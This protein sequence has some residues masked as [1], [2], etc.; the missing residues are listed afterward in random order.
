M[1]LFPSHSGLRTSLQPAPAQDTANDWSPTKT[2]SL[3]LGT[4]NMQ[5]AWTHTLATNSCSVRFK[6][7][8]L[9][10]NRVLVYEGRKES[11]QAFLAVF[12]WEGSSFKQWVAFWFLF[13]LHWKKH[14]KW[15]YKVGLISTWW[16]N[17]SFLYDRNDHFERALY[18]HLLSDLSTPCRA[19]TDSGAFLLRVCLR[20]F[21]MRLSLLSGTC[22][23]ERHE[24][25]WRKHCVR[26]EK[27][28]PGYWELHI[29]SSFI[30][31][32]QQIV[33]ELTVSKAW[34]Q[35]KFKD[36]SSVSRWGHCFSCLRPFLFQLFTLCLFKGCIFY[37]TCPFLFPFLGLKESFLPFSMICQ[38]SK[39]LR[40]FVSFFTEYGRI[41][42]LTH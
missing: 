5:C 13:Y 37:W 4:E 33:T 7:R 36:K 31:L 27:P 24:S 35:H 16:E 1:G 18:S 32:S 19:H 12:T 41:W 26:Q 14:M 17:P 39:H 2:K 11:K 23:P 25:Q 15:N 34:C 38:A 28:P 42:A 6:V 9:K 20:S 40:W 22:S 30:H 8:G 21:V 29:F 10:R 3:S